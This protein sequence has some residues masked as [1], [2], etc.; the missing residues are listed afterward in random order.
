MNKKGRAVLIAGPTASGKSALALARAAKSDGVIVNADSMQVYDVLNVLSARP[1]VDDLAIAEHRLY[2]C[3]SPTTRYSTGQWV[4]DVEKVIQDDALQDRE[5]IFVGGTGLYFEALIKG[6]APVPTV[7]QKVVET[8]EKVIQ[9]LDRAGRREI[10]LARDPKMAARLKEPDQQRVVRA[11]SV[12]EA[13]GKSLADWQDIEP[14]DLL[15]GWDVEKLVLSPDRDV[16]RARVAAR[17]SAMM[18]SGAI[19]EVQALLSLDLDPTLPAMKAIG[20][21]EISAW[22]AGAMRREEM[23][24]R[25]VI[26]TRQY[27]KRQRTWFRRRMAD[28]AWVESSA[29]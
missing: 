12:L 17:Y 29:R 13:T 3:V 6:I 26:A 24:E 2:G 10:L 19:E 5:V 8:F 16:L 18:D 22:L 4:A 20:V 21:P 15:H 27:A 7:P 1:Q 11:L 28:W 9:P 25:A 14:V 23:V